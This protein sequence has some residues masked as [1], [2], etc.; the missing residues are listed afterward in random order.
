L[1]VQSG[2]DAARLMEAKV[3]AEDR[4]DIAASIAGDDQ[5]YA[6]LVKRYQGQVSRWMWRFT[7]ERAVLEELTQEVFVEAYYS[8]GG[9]AG[10]SQFT[11]WLAKIATRVGYHYW[12]REAREREHRR[13]LAEWRPEADDPAPSEA[14]GQLF[15][16][17]A[18][19][20]AKDRLA[21]TL[22]YFD[23]ADV[24]T[25]A[26]R[27]GWSQSLVKVRLFRARKKLKELLGG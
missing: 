5:A 8:L 15:A 7:R 2:W 3:T 1:P 12:Q 14:A 26:E 17:L 9:F 18:R 24:R 10:R 22:Y 27:T 21:L 20:P 25:I 4:Q 13:A 23:E 19:L 11:T 16:L 6:R